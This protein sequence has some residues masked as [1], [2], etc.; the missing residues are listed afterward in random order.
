M[1]GIYG[2]FNIT[3]RLNGTAILETMAL[4]LADRGPDGM[5]MGMGMLADT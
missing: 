4:S 5:G 1:C 3:D 2:F